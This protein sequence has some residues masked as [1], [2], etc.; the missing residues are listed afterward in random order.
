MAEIVGGF[1]VPH[2]PIM[3]YA[4]DAPS[5]AQKQVVLDAYAATARR[6]AELKADTAIIIGCDHYILYGTECLPRYVIST[7]EMDGP[8]D[9]LPGLKR[10]PID[11]HAALG[12]HIC[13][14]GFETGFDW[15]VGRAMAVDHSVAIPHHYMVKP[16]P[17]MKSV[18]VMLACGVDPY[19]PMK[20][21][22]ELGEQIAAAVRSF[23]GSERVVVIGSGGISHHV[24]DERMGE[25]NPDFDKRVLAAVTSG[26][27]AAMLGFTDEIILAEGGNGAMEIRTFACAMAA[28]GAAGGQV[29]AYEP[30]TEWVTGMGFAELRAAA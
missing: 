30:I 17:G 16:N 23:P 1:V 29:V 26:D 6:I 10:E 24:G 25:V 4:P 12:T 22:W 28:V 14:E 11:C 3:F 15:T 7:G 8:V 9:Q 18:A 21:A 13:K 27:K 2:N 20:R 19:L 5:A